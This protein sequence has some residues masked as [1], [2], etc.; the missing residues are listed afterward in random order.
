MET[1]KESK[2]GEEDEDDVPELVGNFEDASKQQWVY[3]IRDYYGSSITLPQTNKLI[4]S[5]IWIY[6]FS[7][8]LLDM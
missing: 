7:L 2:N 4:P 3:V 5:N 1:V 6:S 8:F